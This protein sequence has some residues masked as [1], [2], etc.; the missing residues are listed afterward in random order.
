MGAAIHE[1]SHAIAAIMFNQPFLG[2]S[3]IENE[4]SQGRMVFSTAF[5]RKKPENLMAGAKL[6]ITAIAGS[7]GESIHTG[8]RWQDLLLDG[9]A[10]MPFGPASS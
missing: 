9:A 6:A 1:A 10:L 3:T 5:A 4:T 8:D 7:V 2:I